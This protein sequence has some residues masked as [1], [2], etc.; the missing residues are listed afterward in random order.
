[1][2]DTRQHDILDILKSRE[3]AKNAFERD[4]ADKA[5][6]RI[7][8][9]SPAVKDLRNKL[10]GAIRNN[11]RRAVERFKHD[12]MWLRANDTYGKDY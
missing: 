2:A 8:S 1:M 5:L 12:L 6:A 7:K 10:V 3:S 9:E 4:M 11:D